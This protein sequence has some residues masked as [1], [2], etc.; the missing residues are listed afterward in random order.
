VIRA[1][2]QQ[3][4]QSFASTELRYRD[5]LH[6]PPYG[7]LIAFRLSGMDSEIVRQSAEAVAQ[8]LRSHLN[9]P[10]CAYPVSAYEIL[11]PAPAAIMRVSRRYRWQIL[12]KCLSDQSPSL[13]ELKS[14]RS[15]CPVSVSLTI[16]VDPLRLL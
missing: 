9:P 5:A 11:G 14:L 2:V 8:Q 13:P 12:L 1:V 7:R 6:Y 10:Q 4:Y 16:D 15:L 3:D